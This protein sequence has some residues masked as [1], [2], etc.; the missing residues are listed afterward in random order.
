MATKAAG[1]GW[2]QPQLATLADAAPAGADWLHEIKYDGYRLLAYITSSGVRLLSRNQ[3]DW[4]ARF[5]AI[6]SALS[7]RGPVPLVV[8]GEAAVELENGVTSFQALQNAMRDASRG[9]LQFFAFDL[10]WLG[11]KDVR[12]EPL[13]ERKERLRAALTG[14]PPLIRFSDHV[15]GRGPAFFERACRAGLEGIIS[16][17]ANGAYRSG[18]GTDWLKVKCV[19][20]QEFVIGGFTEPGGSRQGLGALHVGAYDD[21]GQLVYRGKVGTGFSDATLRD[22]RRR[23]NA[24]ERGESPFTAGPRGAAA[25]GSHWVEPKL[26]AQIRF[27]EWT[28]DGRLRHPSF[29]GLREDKDATD[30]KLEQEA[31]TAMKA[32]SS[33]RRRNASASHTTVS[34]QTAS[35]QVESARK[36]KVP[37]QRRSRKEEPATEVGGVRLTSPSRVVY[38]ADG[39]TKLELARY[40]ERIGE[41]ML[42]YI[43]GRPLTLIRCPDNIEECFYQK[44]VDDNRVYDALERVA[45]REEKGVRHYPAVHD[46]KGLLS[47][48]QLGVVEFHTLGSRRDQLEKPDRFTLDLDPDPA[49]PWERVTR[50]ARAIRTVLTELGLTS[51]VK[52]TGGKG[53]HVVVP[54]QRR[55]GWDEVKEFSR[56]V[57][58]LLREA[59]PDE[60]TLRVSK[61][62][63]T[64]KIL[65]DYL[66]NARGSVAVEAFSARARPGAPVSLPIGWDELARSQPGRHTIRSAPKRVQS[67]RDDPW[68]GYFEVKQSITAAMKRQLGM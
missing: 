63:R 49:L 23:L 60:Y 12:S 46:V 22:L 18:R 40:Y 53:L 39:I 25:R 2:V 61:T 24:L 11:G 38:P 5:G 65:L 10:L 45:V 52:T 68:A 57:A 36:S 20:E 9:Q 41:H 51:F 8:D 32:E 26:V 4:T 42:P 34:R 30:V 44:H 7:G 16:K 1:P 37:A 3:K 55:S 29:E 15:L 56:R 47:L 14:A 19:R 17:R 48:V 67:R 21:A 13:L 31:S 58:G 64:G 50:A 33:V 27:T 62:R 43:A 66:R 35:P 6:A 59:A 28:D 54:L